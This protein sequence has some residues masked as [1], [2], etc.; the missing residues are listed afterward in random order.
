[1]H[2]TIFLLH[3]HKK[4]HPHTVFHTTDEDS[5][6]LSKCLVQ[7][8]F[9]LVNCTNS[10]QDDTYY[11]PIN[12]LRTPLLLYF[13][14][15]ALFGGPCL[16][17]GQLL[18]QKMFGDCSTPVTQ[19]VFLTACDQ[20]EKIAGECV[21]VCVQGHYW[22]IGSHCVPP[23]NQPVAPCSPTRGGQTCLHPVP[24]QCVQSGREQRVIERCVR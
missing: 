2:A 13:H 16:E 14:G 18:Y 12:L 10:R 4:K 24:V 3:L 9:W 6:L 15:Q 7:T 11:W 21:C 22:L 19:D 8:K 1:M 17:F 23:H 5:S 20:L